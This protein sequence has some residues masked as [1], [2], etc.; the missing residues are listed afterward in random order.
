[1]QK[2]S[3]RLPADVEPQEWRQKEDTNKEKTKENNKLD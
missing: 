2:G 3:K 1:L